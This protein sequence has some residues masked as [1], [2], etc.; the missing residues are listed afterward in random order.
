MDPATVA[1]LAGGADILGGLFS[2]GSSSKTTLPWLE[3]YPGWLLFSAFTPQGYDAFQDVKPKMFKQ[4]FGKG[5]DESQL[6][7]YRRY[8]QNYDP[9]NFLASG[10]TGR[11]PQPWESDLLDQS[12]FGLTAPLKL[13]G[14]SQAMAGTNNLLAGMFPKSTFN[15]GGQ[16]YGNDVLTPPTVPK[17]SGGQPYGNDI[18]GGLTKMPG[19][20]A[21]G[22][23]VLT[24]GVTQG[25][26]PGAVSYA[27]VLLGKS[28]SSGGTAANGALMLNVG[29]PKQWQTAGVNVTPTTGNTGTTWGSPVSDPEA[30]KAEQAY[31]KQYGTLPGATTTNAGAPQGGGQIPGGTQQQLFGQGGPDRSGLPPY[32][33]YFASPDLQPGVK[34]V[35]GQGWV[36]VPTGADV[37]WDSANNQ[38]YYHG[39]PITQ[40]EMVQLRAEGPGAF[41]TSAYQD[42]TSDV[43]ASLGGQLPV[44]TAPTLDTLGSLQLPDKPNLPAFQ[45]PDVGQLALNTY[46]KFAGQ[47]PG[48]AQAIT[49][50][51]NPQIAMPA[52]SIFDM[53]AEQRAAGGPLD[54]YVQGAIGGVEQAANRRMQQADLALRSRFAGEGSYMSGP[55]L[56]ALGEMYATGNAELANT[57]GQLALSA[58][59]S[60]SGR[61]Y[62]A[63]GTQYTSEL[64][65]NKTEAQIGAQSAMQLANTYGQIAASTGNAQ[66]AAMADAYR[67][68]ANFLAS[69]YGTEVGAL[70]SE[71][72]TKAGFLSDTYKTGLQGALT[73]QA[74]AANEA[75][76]RMAQALQAQGMSF[77]QALAVALATQQNEQSALDALY[78]SYYQPGKNL[79]DALSPFFGLGNVSKTSSGGIF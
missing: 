73:Q 10:G 52:Q 65:R 15:V 28:P 53:V 76:V 14:V 57:I 45:T 46:N 32:P 59:E 3:Q 5:F 47:T 26:A 40:G 35:Q 56:N 11:P 27:D 21:Y 44:P 75:T 62:G 34:Y 29:S 63:A 64:D 13:G 48:F 39:V 30:F 61:V 36:E 16:P 79:L 38:Y 17:P 20:Y 43:F 74:L 70:T 72:G 69:L 18:L 4:V 24:P 68:Q 31:Y 8:V 51:L 6:D 50:A 33:E 54:K 77:E 78:K 22:N 49:N 19:Q 9:F 25:I 42:L 23:D 60:E 7:P 66:A 12:Y 37:V 67:T 71:Y 55:M 1:L 2:G 58:A 41:T